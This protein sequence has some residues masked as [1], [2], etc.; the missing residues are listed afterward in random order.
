MTTSSS[1][2]SSPQQ[3]RAQVRAYLAS[4]PPET[5][6]W[7]RKLRAAVRAAAPGATD[8]FSYGIPG[9]KLDGQPL[10]W[11]AGWKH[12]C[13]LYPMTAAVR[14][15]HAAA[16]RGY[17]TAKGTIRFPLDQPTPTALVK[18]LVKARIAELRKRGK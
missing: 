12:H 14:R 4:L 16:L 7:V 3:V 9:F 18:R 15:A 5:R 6:K 17:K 11:Y 10:L 13:S 1:S 2:R 8:G